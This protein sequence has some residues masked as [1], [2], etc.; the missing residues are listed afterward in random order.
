MKSPQ[1]TLQKVQRPPMSV[2]ENQ[3][4]VSYGSIRQSARVGLFFVISPLWLG[5]V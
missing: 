2:L 3:L 5:L 1:S 4:P